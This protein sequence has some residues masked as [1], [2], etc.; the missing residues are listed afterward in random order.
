MSH[1]LHLILNVAVAVAIALLGGLLAHWLRQ[2]VIVGYLVAGMAIGPF[3]PG[4]IGDRTQIASLAEVG[5]VFLMFA[6]GIEFSLKELATVKGVALFGTAAQI[7]L[8]MAAG[9]GL[10]LTLGWPLTQGLF[11]GGVIAISSTM[12][13]L[14]T[15]LDRGEVAS[16]HGRVLLGMLIVQDLAVVILIVLLPKLAADADAALYDLALT[17]VKAVAFIGATLFLGARVVPR[18]MAGVE[19]LGSAELFLLTAVVLALGTAV[20]SALLGLSPALGAFMAGLMLTE[21]EFDHRVIAEVVPMRNLFATLFFVS[22]G[23]LI[24]PEFIA[25]NF[26]TVIGLALFI[27]VAKALITMAVILPFELGG[28]TT[29]FTS[30]GMIQIGEFSYVLARSGREAGAIPDTLYSLILTSSLLTIV[31][32]PPAFW[33]APRVDLALARVPLLG[34]LFAARP[35]T[36]ADERAL[37]HH[38]IVVGYGRVGRRVTAGL[39]EAGL[40][41]VVVEQDLH[42]VQELSRVGIPTVYGEASYR[43]ILAA[44]HPERARLIVVALPDSGATRATVLNARRANPTVP[45]LARIAR[46]EDGEVLRRVGVTAVVAPEQA[47]AL[48]LLDESMRSLG[49]AVTLRNAIT[50]YADWDHQDKASAAEPL[51][52]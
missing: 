2:S 38:A 27:M 40:P 34:R 5:V 43:T 16:N 14:K 29:V 11:F 22:V 25:R 51:R 28:K 46:E 24:D 20:V 12:V 6:L 18:L 33:V 9:V 47:G 37:D 26:L 7:V 44:A 35:V 13:I 3:T 15:L 52:G 50:N 42:L 36:T 49:L 39:H 17:L 19:R 45:I 31:L 21:T 10:G 48:Q 8:T 41:V 4:F 32:T 1:E 30:L 23:M